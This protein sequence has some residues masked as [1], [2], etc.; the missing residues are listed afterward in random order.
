MKV[1]DTLR[2][3]NHLL[4]TTCGKTLKQFVLKADAFQKLP[5]RWRRVWKD[6]RWL[7][8]CSVG[9][10]QSQPELPDEI[11]Q[12][13]PSQCGLFLTMDQAA[14]GWS[15]GH[16]LL[17]PN[18]FSCFGDMRAACPCHIIDPFYCAFEVI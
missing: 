5:P 3:I 10:E 4:V 12:S 1:Y 2:M 14:W 16:F 8:E 13:F 9:K 11:L 17:D 15:A 18:G 6:H 7:R